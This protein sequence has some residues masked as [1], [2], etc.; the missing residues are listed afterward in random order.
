M[1][2][3]LIVS[4]VSIK[5]KPKEEYKKVGIS[6][7]LKERTQNMLDELGKTAML[8]SNDWVDLFEFING[9]DVPED[10]EVKEIAEDTIKE[11]GTCGDR[12]DVTW[13]TFPERTVILAG[14]MSFGDNPSEG[15]NIIQKFALLPQWLLDAGEF[16]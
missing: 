10:K 4:Y 16:E 9:E 6:K 11:F 13:L 8:D 15:C 2:E 7:D 14:G 12:R 3:D 1:G 5:G